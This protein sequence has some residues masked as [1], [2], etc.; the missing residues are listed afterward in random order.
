MQVGEGTYGAQH[1]SFFDLDQGSELIIGKYCSIAPGVKAILGGEH[2]SHRITMYPFNSRYGFPSNDGPDGYTK[3][4]I[5]I[6]NDVWIGLDVTIMSGVTIG[7]GAVIAARSHVVKDVPAYTVVGGNPA[8][9]IKKRYSLTQEYLLQ[10]IK[11]WDWPISRIEEY[12]PLLMSSNLDG[13]LE[14]CR[15]NNLMGV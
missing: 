4:N 6:G 13:F 3:G 9:V 14:K 15:E 5:V 1:I 10:G 2:K 11:W 8:I 7:N 12:A